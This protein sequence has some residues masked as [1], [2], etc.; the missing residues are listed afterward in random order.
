MTTTNDVLAPSTKEVCP[1]NT[2]LAQLAARA[3]AAHQR[4]FKAAE[5]GLLA[6]FEAGQAL[7]QARKLCLG[8]FLAW[9]PQNFKY[10]VRTADRYMEFAEHCYSLGGFDSTRVSSL[11]P[12]ELG[13]IWSQILGRRGGKKTRCLPSAGG[14]EARTVRSAG[15][16]GER[17]RGHPAADVSARVP[18]IERTAPTRGEHSA[19]PVDRMPP[20]VTMLAELIE[21]CR[22]VA[23]GDD[24]YDGE[25]AECLVTA[26][27]PHYDE[28]L[29]YMKYRQEWRSRQERSQAELKPAHAGH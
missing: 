26:L 9:L 28:L 8:Q 23:T 24:C 22:R 14:K 7:L 27:E 16:A 15:V 29:D 21:E 11:P 4:V 5:E 12:Q 13:R 18:A 19:V 6:A 25:Y 10:S 3:N 17:H 2:Q 1:V 20:L